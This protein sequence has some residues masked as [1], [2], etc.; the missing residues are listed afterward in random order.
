MTPSIA[1]R[2]KDSFYA[3]TDL[4][5]NMLFLCKRLDDVYGEDLD[6]QCL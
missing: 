6:L 2:G 3:V 4:G 1:A 5:V